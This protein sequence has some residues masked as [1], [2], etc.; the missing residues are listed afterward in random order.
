MRLDVPIQSVQ[1]DIVGGVTLSGVVTGECTGRLVIDL[2]P[3]PSGPPPE[4]GSQPDDGEESVGGPLTRLELDTVGAFSMKVPEGATGALAAL[5]DA[6]GDG[7]IGRDDL[8]SEAVELDALAASV[9]D[10]ALALAPAS[11]PGTTR[12]GEGKP[13]SPGPDGGQAPA[14]GKP[15]APEG[16]HPACGK[17][18]GTPPG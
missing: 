12:G 6:D 1:A 8:A 9:A 16:E 2:M 14:D 5:C 7:V 15:A 11:D 13:D 4:P 10:L 17:P 18:P 3:P